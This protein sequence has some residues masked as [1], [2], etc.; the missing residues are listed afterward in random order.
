MLRTMWMM[1]LTLMAMAPTISAQQIGCEVT[2]P[3]AFRLLERQNPRSGGPDYP[4]QTHVRAITLGTVT[5]GGMRAVRVRIDTAEGWVF[6]WPAQIRA[7][8]A[9][10]V[11]QRPGD[12]TISS[13]SPAAPAAPPTPPQPARAC[14]PG[15]TQTCLCVGGATGVQECAPTGM[16]YT[17]CVCAA[18]APPREAAPTPPLREPSV[19]A[20]A[21][22][23]CDPGERECCDG[24]L[25]CS[26]L[27][28]PSPTH[29]RGLWGCRPCGRLGQPCCRGSG[30]TACPPGSCSVGL[31]FD[32]RTEVCRASAP[33]APPVPVE[34]GSCNTYGCW[35]TP[36]GS[37]NSYGCTEWGECNS[38]G[39]PRG[40]GGGCNSYGCWS[41]N[42]GCNS[43]GCWTNGGGCNSYG[44]WNSPGGSCTYRG[45]SG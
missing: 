42:G 9:G 33:E 24:S 34:R 15:A 7:C 44:C 13:A 39:C 14:V 2:M 17:S 25:R 32:P 21:G 16:A 45:C 4:A 30:T 26:M 40:P 11:A 43:Y 29:R 6:L 27:A 19:C 3:R 28:L 35:H 1:A 18:P 38:Y 10:S 22:E 20:G 8:P 23:A 31:T 12:V 37:C 36:S 5:Q 41:T